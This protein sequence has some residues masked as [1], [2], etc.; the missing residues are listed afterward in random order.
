MTQ[1]ELLPNNKRNTLAW[2]T[3]VKPHVEAKRLFPAVANRLSSRP[4]VL[5]KENP[6]AALVPAVA[7]YGGQDGVDNIVERAN[8]HLAF[9]N[10]GKL[11]GRCASRGAA[12]TRVTHR[13]HHPFNEMADAYTQ[14]PTPI[15]KRPL[16]RAWGTVE[17]ADAMIFAGGDGDGARAILVSFVEPTSRRA[18]DDDDRRRLQ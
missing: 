9:T 14:G 15:R 7:A 8:Q 18:D 16:E 12:I 11:I 1:T 6:G 17:R 3:R 2:Q 5:A 13:R 10:T 4:P